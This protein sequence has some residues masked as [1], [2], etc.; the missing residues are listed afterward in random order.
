LKV[1]VTGGAGFIGSHV[2]E[3]FFRDGWEVLVIDDFSHGRRENL[4]SNIDFLHLDINTDKFYKIVKDFSPDVI[5][6]QAAQVSVPYSWKNPLEDER[7]NIEGSLKVVLAAKESGAKRLILA[8][9][10]AVYG[11]PEEIP[12]KESHPLNPISPYGLS[13]MVAEKYALLFQEE[14]EVVVLRYGNVYGPRQVSEGEAGVVSIFLNRLKN[15]TPPIIYGDGSQ[16]RDFIYVEDVA[17]ANILAVSGE[18]GVY[19]IGTG[20]EV[21]V[22]ELARMVVSLMSSSLSP[23]YH[24]PRPGDIYRIFL[25]NS[26]AERKLGWKPRF[27]LEEGLKKTVESFGR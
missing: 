12:V 18:P 14:L 9:S 26:L 24:S 4:S 1:L 20:K 11:E 10:V 25:D 15:N 8:S 16:T 22:N 17:F 13:K 23:L 6:H 27:N 3:A 21:T 2:A 5:S 7:R 19:N